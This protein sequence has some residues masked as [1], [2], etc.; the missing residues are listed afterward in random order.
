MRFF[1]RNPLFLFLFRVF[2]LFYALS[3]L[4]NVRAETVDI[5][6]E[7]R[8]G[9][10]ADIS[11]GLYI[12]VT[13]NTNGSVVLDGSGT[14]LNVSGND[15]SVVSISGIGSLL[16]TDGAMLRISAD[17][18]GNNS[19]VKFNG[20]AHFVGGTLLLESKNGGSAL[21]STGMT[22][23][24]VRFEN[25][26]TLTGSGTIEAGNGVHVNSGSR[27][28]LNE[29][30]DIL[31]INGNL[32][33]DSTSHVVVSAD[34][35]GSS[36]IEITGTTELGGTL[37]LDLTPEYYGT[38]PLDYTVLTST[39]G[40]SNNFNAYRLLQNRYGTAAKSASSTSNDLI[41]TLTPYSDPHGRIAETFNE[42]NT[43]TALDS[44]Y[45]SNDSR[46]SGFFKEVMG[47]SDAQARALYHE[48]SG[49]I[50]AD[51]L[52][53]MPSVGISKTAFDRVTWDS[54]YGHVL[55]G[56]QYRLVA[57][58][59]NRSV[60]AEFLYDHHQVDSDTNAAGYS[61]K[62]YGVFGGVDQTLNGGKTAV[63]VIFG[64]SS[65]ELKRGR[66]KSEADDYMAGIYGASRIFNALELK[67]WGGIGKQYYDTSRNAYGRHLTSSHQ[68][69][70][71]TAS[72]EVAMPLYT[73]TLLVLKPVVGYD[74]QHMKTGE[75]HETG[76]PLIA[77]NGGKT[78][79]DRQIG[80]IGLTGEL[81]ES[82]V[83]LFGGAHYRYLLGGD[84]YAVVTNRFVGGG[85]AFQITGVDLGTSFV[86]CQLG[87][88][89]TL[90]PE[91]TRMIFSDYSV[92]FGKRSTLQT[93]S[94]GFQQTY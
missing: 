3:V 43:G 4:Q 79:I 12:G 52:M 37:I 66:D 7:V 13:N 91:R 55:F 27:I 86:T 10:V 61:L 21:L 9:A 47:M 69:T 39:A 23:G 25:G 63:G 11:T 30:D 85:N 48:L 64:Y 5:S 82:Y 76:D 58:S 60:W 33:L 84:S 35:S 89:I 6:R 2:T 18:S 57:K 26:S 94:I 45:R 46:W 34:K 41:V 29:A 73:N 15:P 54:E 75:F 68:G 31:K 93:G 83:H 56:P 53:S 59:N 50:Y 20:H 62:R 22:T 36:K 16:V 67:L 81:G 70:N 71:V 14:R 17:G 44:V 87:M 8:H 90:N 19:E 24:W 80:R 51:A 32:L 65:P 72:A 1:K 78:S 74:Y 49:E 88:Q 77:L 40:Y 42:W 38:A 92:D 28:L